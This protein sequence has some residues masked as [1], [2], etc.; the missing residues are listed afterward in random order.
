MSAPVDSWHGYSHPYQLRHKNRYMNVYFSSVV[1]VQIAGM[2]ESQEPILVRC[3]L[4]CCAH[5]RSR[6]PHATRLKGGAIADHYLDH[7]CFDRSHRRMGT[8]LCSMFWERRSRTGRVF[9]QANQKISCPILT[10]CLTSTVTY[11]SFKGK[12]CSAY[13]TE[14]V[15]E[16]DATSCHQVHRGLV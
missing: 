11:L 4:L 3:V 1:P 10:L 8:A 6:L 16:T 13:L 15:I 7:S 2:D 14:L 12:C 5:V 9:W